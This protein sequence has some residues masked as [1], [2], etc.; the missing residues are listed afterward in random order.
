MSRMTRRTLGLSAAGFAAATALGKGARA[1]EAVDPAK[2]LDPELRGVAEMIAKAPMPAP[3]DA[4]VALMRQ[5]TAGFTP[6]PL[7]SPPV[8]FRTI[9]GPPGAPPVKVL[10]TGLKADVPSRPAVLHIH[11]GGFITGSAAMSAADC[12][13][14]AVALDCVVVSVDYRL[15]PETRFPGAL[16]DNYAALRWLHDNARELGVDRE[17]IA[18]K[19]ESAGG[20]HAAMLAIAARDRGEY[21]ICCQVLIYPMLDDRTGSTRMP[22]AHIG[23]YLWTAERNRYGWSALL[24]FAPGSAEPPPGAVPARVANLAGLPPTFIGVGA[25]DL[26]VDEDVAY[27]RR[28][29]DAAVP[30]ELLVMPGAIHGFDGI[31]PQARISRE[32]TAAWQSTL[33]AAFAGRFK[34]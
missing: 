22:P 3:S 7:A 21:R 2:L 32:F 23:T 1:S 25:L 31:A 27:A 19:G 5:Q 4:T 28:L 16:D 12:Q 29:V 6:P 34:S 30:T 14:L 15:A 24:G 9:P 10:V 13:R 17:R 11:G 20:G 18:V 8:T 26:F 33:A